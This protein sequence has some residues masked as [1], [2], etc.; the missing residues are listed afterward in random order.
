MC[1]RDSSYTTSP[2]HRLDGFVTMGKRLEDLGADTIC[3]KDMALSLIH[4]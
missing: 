4:I 2:V 1:I 3:I